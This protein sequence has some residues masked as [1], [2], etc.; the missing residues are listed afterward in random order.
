MKATIFAIV[1]AVGGLMCTTL[2][3]DTAQSPQIKQQIDYRGVVCVQ[4]NAEWNV[5]N[6]YPSVPGLKNY[7]IDISKDPQH[8]EKCKIKSLPTLIFYKDGKEF[9]RVDGGLAFKITAPVMEIKKQI[10]EAI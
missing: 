1:C 3:P 10:D 4:Y 6:R 5:A 2:G 8:K 7:Y 9:K